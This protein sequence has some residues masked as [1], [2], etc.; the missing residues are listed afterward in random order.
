MNTIIDILSSLDCTSNYTHV[1]YYPYYLVK[2]KNK[3]K[4]FCFKLVFGVLHS[5]K[6]VQGLGKK[7]LYGD[8]TSKV[9]Q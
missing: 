5:V 1:P 4:I 8:V 3:M 6:Q 7:R 2:L 9:H